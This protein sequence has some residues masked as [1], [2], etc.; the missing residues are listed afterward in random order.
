MKGGGREGGVGEGET[1]AD[2]EGGTRGEDSKAVVED[3]GNA[4]GECA[5]AVIALGTRHRP[6]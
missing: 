2:E 1:A 4:V 3:I 5:V 6:L